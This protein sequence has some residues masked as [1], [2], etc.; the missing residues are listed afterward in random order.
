MNIK[1]FLIGGA[2][3]A[4]VLGIGAVSVLAKGGFTSARIFNGT[5]ASYCLSVDA[6]TTCAGNPYDHVIMKW[7]AQWDNCN[8]HGYNTAKYCLGAW[9]DNE[10]N[11]NV[12]NGSGGV[13]HYK[14][15]WVGSAEQSSVYWLP[16]GY[17]IWGNYEVIMDQ[18]ND[19]YDY[20]S[21]NINGGGHQ[22][23]TL[24]TP[25]GYGSVFSK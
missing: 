19:S 15:I 22:L 8:A 7:N 14:I 6:P 18:G 16:G 11:G 10:F 25:N 20:C 9:V 23:C 13:W 21:T 24:A 1:K 3:S 5:T 4:L 2:V 12:P 17:P